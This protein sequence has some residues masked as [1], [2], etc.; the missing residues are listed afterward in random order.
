[1][2]ATILTLPVV[3]AHDPA[4]S[5]PTY[6]FVSCAPNTVGVGQY[7]LIV[8]WVNIQPVT[9]SGEGGDRWRGFALDITKPDGTTEHIPYLGV[10]SAIGSA[11]IQYAPD[12]VGDYSIVFSWPGQTLANGTAPALRLNEYVGDFHEGSTSEPAILHVQQDPIAD[13]VEPP[14]PDYWTRPIPT[15]NREWAQLASNYLKGSWLR[16]PHWQEQGQAPNSAHILWTKEVMHGGIADER[17]A[18][19]KLDTKD[20]EVFLPPP[21]V[22]A[23]KIYYNALTYPNYGY[24]CVDL[25]T[26]ET[27]YY[28]NGTDNGLN[29]PF[30]LSQLNTR[31][32]FPQ[33][34]FGQL[35]HYY[36]VNGE[37]VK[38]HLWMV[39]GSTWYMLDANTGNWVLT[40][41]NVPSGEDVTDQNGNILRYRYYSDTGN[42]L[43]W[44]VSQSIPP[45]GPTGTDQQQWEPPIGATI[46]AINDTAWWDYGPNPTG[47]R[48]WYEDDILPR[49]GYTMNVTGPKGL[50]SAQ[51]KVL[52]DVNNVPKMIVLYDFPG[53]PNYPMATTEQYFN[54]AVLR[55]DQT[56]PYSPFPDKTATQNNNLG[57]SVSLLWNK[58]IPFPIT[59]GNLTFSMGST[60]WGGNEIISY[61]DE[62]FALWCKEKRQYWGY[63]LNNGELLWG[64]T[65]PT[66]SMD[67]YAT[68]SNA[69]TPGYFAY[70]KLYSAAYAGELQAYDIKTG[71]L[72]W[73]YTATNIGRESPYGNYPL[74]TGTIADGKL[75]MVSGEHSATQ[76]M[77]RG[78]YIRC[79]DAETGEEKWRLQHF[80][81][82]NNDHWLSIADGYIIAAN[83]YDGQLYCIG[84][85]LSATTVTASPKVSVHGSS[86]LIEGTVIDTSPGAQKIAERTGSAVAAVADEDQ[87][88]WMEYLY[89]QQACPTTGKGVE[90]TLDTIDPNGNWIHIGRVTS[91][92]SG[93][94]SL[95][96]TPDVPGKYTIIATF[97][98]S[99]SYGSS[100]AE[101][102]IFVS[103]APSPAQPIEPEPTT[104]EPTTPEP[105]TPEP[106]TPE[107]TTPEPT[108]PEPTEPEPTEATEAPLITTEV[109]II[110]AV[111]IASIIGVV[112]FWALRKRK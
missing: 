5:I 32:N 55:I 66:G 104:P 111:L 37:G 101:T 70:G 8:M 67:Y 25:R 68:G 47:G 13:W 89:M 73:D 108:T 71:E 53:R 69:D 29:N 105:T 23:G 18:A 76:P 27:D 64:P 96:F 33:L 41:K 94:Y 4:W 15:M 38:D 110:A 44:N 6:A 30:T 57:Y 77:W 16:Y 36:G 3:V 83:E 107:P 72:L 86:V 12:Q 56:G 61:D 59:T 7:T 81:M 26:G 43:C 11:W 31:Q 50:P 90:V 40:I 65:A 75:Y 2:S 85:G 28:K 80:V 102:A 97:E 51:M 98:G 99:E 58:T 88:A 74:T 46:D 14:L 21:I 62:V 95:A 20:Y 17:Y 103:E 10:T 42:F 93:M 19:V 84:K 52:R 106:T 79:L 82:E 91:D 34:S 39:R 87:Q 24:Y 9:A 1:M 92:M 78:A 35:Y 60:G 112:S 49:S 109:A 63:D 22:M 45:P 100:Y 54:M 48:P